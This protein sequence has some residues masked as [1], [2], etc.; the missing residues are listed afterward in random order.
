MSVLV[1]DD[2]ATNRRILEEILRNWRMKPTSVENGR[3]ALALMEKANAE[4]KSFPLILLDAQMPHMDGFEVAGRIKHDSRLTKAVIVMLTSAGQSGDAARCREA[5]IDAYLSKPIKRTEL[6]EA[7]K[8]VLGAQGHASG[9]ASV[10]ADP[11]SREVTRRLK[12]LL[13]EDNRVNQAVAMRLLTKR[14]DIRR[15]PVE[16]GSRQWKKSKPRHSTDVNGCADAGNG[17]IR[18]DR[19]DPALE[20]TLSRH[21]PI[22]AM[23]AHAMVGDRE[24]CSSKPEW[25]AIFRSLCK[26]R[27]FSRR[28]RNSRPKNQPVISP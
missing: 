11:A 18:S 7:I 21:I 13:A 25:T 23:T 19:S 27:T 14:P 8:R 3:E 16:T 17:R 24:R 9:K 26:S 22:I 12:I 2:N 4:G 15:D 6:L 10:V 28:L 5:G 20:K 1:V